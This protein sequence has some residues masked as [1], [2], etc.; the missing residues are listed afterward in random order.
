MRSWLSALPV[1]LWACL[2]G[3]GCGGQVDESAS[4]PE[5]TATGGADAGVHGADAADEPDAGTCGVI[6][7]SDY[8]QS[9]ITDQDCA[10]VFE[11][12]TCIYQCQCPN[13]VVSRSALAYYPV[14]PERAVI[15]PCYQLPVPPTCTGGV[16]T[17]C[18]PTG[19][20]GG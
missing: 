7:A 8:D 13:A 20:D 2:G 4:H 17:W 12:D 14:F 16:C 5:Q 11:G 19:C 15:C 9:C 6:R 3:H 1:I 10:T 18:P